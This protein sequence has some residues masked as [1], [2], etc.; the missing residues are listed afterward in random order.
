MLPPASVKKLRTVKDSYNLAWHDIFKHIEP[1]ELDKS[2]RATSRLT[3]WSP[4]REVYD[5]RSW[6]WHRMRQAC[7]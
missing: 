2:V 1:Q 6:S 3:A 4:Y 5:S 7:L